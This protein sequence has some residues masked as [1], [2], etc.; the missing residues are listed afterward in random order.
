MEIGFVLHLDQEAA[1]LEY[2]EPTNAAWVDGD[3]EPTNSVLFY[4]EMMIPR[5]LPSLLSPFVA[6][7]GNLK[8]IGEYQAVEAARRRIKDNLS[9]I[10]ERVYVHFEN[11]NIE[12]MGKNAVELTGGTVPDLSDEEN[13]AGWLMAATRHFF[14]FFVASPSM[15]SEAAK[16]AATAVVKHQAAVRDFAAQYISSGR[17]A[18]LWKEIKSVRRQ[19]MELYESLLPLLM[20]RRYW[21]EEHQNITAYDLSVKNFEDLKGF[22]IDCV[23]TSF[24]LLVIGLGFA[25]IG[26]T[27]FTAINTRKGDKDIWWFE[28]MNNGIKH[29]QLDN[30]PV[31]APIVSALDLGLRNG[32]GHHSAHYEVDSDTIVY[33]KADDASLATTSIQYTVFVDQVFRAYCAFEAATMFYQF[34]FVAG[35]G[36]LKWS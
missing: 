21:R 11:G 22:Y 17:M 9:P 7:A 23:E 2:D 18:A 25:L 13:R 14:D 26:D 19:F 35:R 30:Y 15:N 8:D 10:I 4:P 34:L 5:G 24:R 20:V 32:V 33:V 27:G 28:Q 1:S 16:I 6:T 29:T 31:F 12:L 36:R 3:N